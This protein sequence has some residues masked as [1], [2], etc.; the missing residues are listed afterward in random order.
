MSSTP[1][2]QSTHLAT[3]T[4]ED[5]FIRNTSLCHDLIG[6]LTFTEMACFLILGKRPSRAECKVLDACLVTLMEHGL[7]P[8]AI[9]ARLV[10]SSAPEA[11]QAA[12]AGGL[13]GVGSVFAGSMEGCGAL[14]SR[15]VT[16]QQ[17]LHAH[18]REIV[19]EHRRAELSRRRTK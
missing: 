3:S 7:T 11:L 9:S 10:Y 5:V 6:K 17:D 8:S 16:S 18:A 13:L 2:K 14:L 1:R 15:M 19:E 12:V 4:R